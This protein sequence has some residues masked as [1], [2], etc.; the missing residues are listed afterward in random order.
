LFVV[1]DGSS[2][3]RCSGRPPKVGLG[4]RFTGGGPPHLRAVAW[5]LC[6]EARQQEQPAISPS[7]E[8]GS[9]RNSYHDPPLPLTTST[10]SRPQR[11]LKSPRCLVVTR[12]AK[13]SPSSSSQVRGIP[14]KSPPAKNLLMFPADFYAPSSQLVRFANSICRIR[15]HFSANASTPEP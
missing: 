2:P 6:P 10:L 15:T 9:T 1:S 3:E 13:P 11:H 14:Q 7:Y 8:T 4:Y 5:L 12:S